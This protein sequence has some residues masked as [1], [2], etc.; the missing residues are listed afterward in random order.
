MVTHLAG[1][2]VVIEGRVIQRC[3]IC[4]EKLGDSLG[5]QIAV[6]PDGDEPTYATWPVGSWVECDG[7]RSSVVGETASPTFYRPDLPQGCC[8][9]LVED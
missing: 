1:T 2:P 3:L 5:V 9:D 8:V 4:G 6:E 7:P